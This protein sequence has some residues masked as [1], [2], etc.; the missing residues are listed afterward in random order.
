MTTAN[1]HNISWLLS[2]PRDKNEKI[3]SRVRED[4]MAGIQSR[5]LVS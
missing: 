3:D 4:K 2:Q 5:K 1:D